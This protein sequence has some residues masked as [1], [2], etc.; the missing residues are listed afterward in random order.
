MV[1][2]ES[3]MNFVTVMLVVAMAMMA[4]GAGMLSWAMFQM[5]GNATDKANEYFGKAKLFL[6]APTAMNVLSMGLLGVLVMTR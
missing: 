1:L 2:D 6:I 3:S 4:M 5:A